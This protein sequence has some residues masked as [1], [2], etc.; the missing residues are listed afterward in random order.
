MS[1]VESPVCTT[2]ILS[3]AA[4][5]GSLRAGRRVTDGATVRRS[6]LESSM[7]LALAALERLSEDRFKGVG[8][9]QEAEVA[10]VGGVSGAF[11][12]VAV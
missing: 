6:C 4:G 12:I 8:L 1:R 9:A 5:A 3:V 7:I 11:G 2:D 10:G